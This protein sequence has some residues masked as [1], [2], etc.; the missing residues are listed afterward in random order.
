[1]KQHGAAKWV[2]L[3]A[4]LPGRTDWQCRLRWTQSLDT[5]INRGPWTAS[6][7]KILIDAHKKLGNKWAEISKLIDGRTD[8]QCR[9]RWSLVLD[10]TIQRSRWSAR[11]DK[12]LMDAHKK[13][14]NKWVEISK[15]IAGRTDKQCKQRWRQDAFQKKLN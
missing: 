5:T 12:I 10:S 15:L 3:A 13:L 8:N 7:D 14:G 6:E 2:A 11:E 9:H 1:M 4:T